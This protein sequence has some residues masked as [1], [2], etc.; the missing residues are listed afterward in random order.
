MEITKIEAPCQYILEWN[1]RDGAIVLAIEKSVFEEIISRI[2]GDKGGI[3]S[4]LQEEFKPCHKRQ[5][6]LGDF[7]INENRIGFHEVLGKKEENDFVKLSFKLPKNDKITR[8]NLFEAF[9]AT[10][11]VL[12]LYLEKYVENWQKKKFLTFGT[13]TRKSRVYGGIIDA[14]ISLN[15]KEWLISLGNTELEEIIQAML[16]ASEIIRRGKWI[17]MTGKWTQSTL[18][19]FGTTMEEGYNPVEDNVKAR[20]QDGGFYA[21]FFGGSINPKER[22]E[23]KNYGKGYELSC[24]NL[25][26]FWQQLH[27]L[28]ALAF[29][30]NMYR[31]FL[32]KTIF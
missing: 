20:V 6:G 21:F 4:S 22:Y 30:C 5:H 14:W 16:N 26:N 19:D 24:H 27:L 3:I 32:R 28:I 11:T 1:S 23:L 13:G 15:M 29:L 2:L 17:L 7:V 31:D 9:S 12:T 18:T 10:M 25:D 8:H